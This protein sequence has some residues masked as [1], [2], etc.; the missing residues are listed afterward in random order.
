MDLVEKGWGGVDW[1]IIIIIIIII[2]LTDVE[3]CCIQ[4]TGWH[5]AQSAL[6]I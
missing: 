5:R 1:I 6:T 3:L 4:S 2:N